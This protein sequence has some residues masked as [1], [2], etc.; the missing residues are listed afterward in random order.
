MPERF[1]PGKFVVFEGNDGAGKS[2]QA[3]LI[4][5]HAAS[6]GM[7][8]VGTK[9]PG[10][11]PETF[12][13]RGLIFDSRLSE[14]GEGQLLL[15]AAERKVHIEWQ[16]LPALEEGKL[17]V[18]DRFSGS[19]FAYQHERGVFLRTITMLDRIARTVKK[20]GQVVELSPDLTILV[21]VPSEVGIE[22]MAKRRGERT[23]FDADDVTRHER[24]R[25]I[26]LELAHRFGW[27]VI[28]GTRN[29]DEVFIDILTTLEN[30]GILPGGANRSG[31]PLA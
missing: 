5:A 7:D 25:I 30:R 20:N 11:I 31:G 15:F 1:Y 22:R 16:V 24:R 14:D 19:T 29:K 10:G 8:V 18:C 9:E 21:D 17:V 6:L 13:F 4:V 28:D 2:T 12:P 26:F 23:Y 27:V 3:D